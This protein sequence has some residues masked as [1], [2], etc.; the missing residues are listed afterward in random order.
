MARGLG[1]V[2]SIER[3][4]TDDVGEARTVYGTKEEGKK[5]VG[6]E[7]RLVPSHAYIRPP[8]TGGVRKKHH[9]TWRDHLWRLSAP[10]QCGVTL[11]RTPGFPRCCL[12]SVQP[13]SRSAHNNAGP[14][15]AGL[16][17]LRH[18]PHARSGPSAA[19]DTYYL[20]RPATASSTPRTYPASTSSKAS[21]SLLRYIRS[22]SQP[23][24]TPPD[25][26]VPLASLYLLAPVFVSR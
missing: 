23:Y 26:P 4:G 15:L 11:P 3:D 18:M 22:R 12:A 8:F 5:R 20:T 14:R 21:M 25:R 10:V 9:L 17:T 7:F 13:S 6:I 1:V 2:V 24:P 19:A 16:R